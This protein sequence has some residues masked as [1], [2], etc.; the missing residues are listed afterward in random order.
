VRAVRPDG[1]VLG[2]Y[3]AYDS[4]W[5]L[6][7]KTGVGDVNGDGDIEIITAPQTGGPHIKVFD[8]AGTMIDQFMAYDAGFRGGVELIVGN[9]DADASSEIITAP[10][11][12]GG[13]NVRIFNGDN[14]YKATSFM[15]LNSGFRGGV[16]LALSQ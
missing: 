14:K 8:T 7:V 6:G 11:I 3:F 16:N 4:A 12:N 13:P 5:R 2:A 15:A 9:V 1:S 10:K